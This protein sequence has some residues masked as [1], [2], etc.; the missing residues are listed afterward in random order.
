MGSH[1]QASYIIMR[2]RKFCFT[3]KKILF[4]FAGAEGLN[5]ASNT[6]KF[7]IKLQELETLPVRSTQ[8]AVQK[9]VEEEEA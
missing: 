2:P 7:T 3:F 6:L 1:F 9:L 4:A 8:N 5:K